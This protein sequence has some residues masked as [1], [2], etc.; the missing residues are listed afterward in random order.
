MRDLVRFHIARLP[1]DAEAVLADAANPVRRRLL[2]QAAEDECRQILFR[3]YKSYHGLP[4]PGIV[5]RLL[6][7]NVKNHRHL[8][9]LFFAWNPGP[10]PDLEA[11]LSQ[12]LG[13]REVDIAP[14]EAQRL[15]LAYGNPHLNLKDY[16]YLLRRDPLELWGAGEMIRDPAATWARFVGTQR[17]GPTSRFF[18]ALPGPPSPGTRH[19]CPHPN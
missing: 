3:A 1:Y 2:D 9:M 11:T 19:P 18:L 7:R 12:W 14:K 17:A 10:H 6:G 15:I 5:E 4:S 8:A 13:D 16:G